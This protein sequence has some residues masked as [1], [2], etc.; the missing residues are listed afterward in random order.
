VTGG[1]AVIARSAADG[2]FEAAGLADGAFTITTAADRSVGP[3]SS[4]GRRLV[5]DPVAANAGD[6][7]VRLEYRP[8]EPIAGRVV[9][10]DGGVPAGELLV[11]ARRGGDPPAIQSVPVGADGAFTLANTTAGAWTLAVIDGRTGAPLALSG[12]AEFQGGTKDARLVVVSSSAL[13]GRVVDERGRAVG[14]VRVVARGTG[15]RTVEAVTDD[16]G[17]FTWTSLGEGTWDVEAAAHETGRAEAAGVA[18]GAPEVVLTLRPTE[19]VTARVVT[20]DG[21][22]LRGAEV[23]LAADGRPAIARLRT[24]ADGRFSSRALPPGEYA[25]TLAARDGRAVDPPTALG[26]VRSG[27]AETVLRL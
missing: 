27:A 5:T 12:A 2:R 15:G 11:Q 25:V 14:L 20:S 4:F 16:D 21:S 9:R 19:V 24:D 17:R 23:L 10:E 22:P 13:S 7:D 6:R 3:P 26:R 8:A 18:P 1:P